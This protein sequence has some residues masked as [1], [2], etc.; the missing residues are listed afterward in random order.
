MLGIEVAKGWAA[1]ISDGW[2]ETEIPEYQVDPQKLAHLAIICDGNRRA[3]MQMHLQPYLGHLAG[4]EV[5]KG[6]ARAARK[7]RIPT[8][9]FWVWSTENWRRG[10]GQVDFVMSLATEHLSR[11]DF[12]EELIDSE[13]RF[14]HI[15]RRGKLPP[16]LLRTLKNL[17]EATAHLAQYKL[18]LALDYGGKDEMIRVYRRMIRAGVDEEILKDDPNTINHFLDTDGQPAVD[19]VI[20]TGVDKGELPHTSGF[21]P[22]QTADATWI[23]LPDLFPNLTPEKLLKAIKRFEGYERRLGR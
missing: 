10:K 5:V 17:E 12:L 4:L 14:T 23:F 8:V 3:A 18:N 9:T 15:G 13:A 11:A 22:L 21:M 19:L 20:R 16:S 2:I 6:V 7:W 1:D